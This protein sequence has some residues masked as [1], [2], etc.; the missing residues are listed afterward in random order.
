MSQEPDINEILGNALVIGIENISKRTLETIKK[1]WLKGKYGFTPIPE[2]ATRL[3]EISTNQTYITFKKIVG[4]YKYT[5]YI[6]IGILLYELNQKGNRER[7]EE[8]K[9][10][11]YNSRDGIHAKYIIHIASTGVLL[12]VLEYL[13]DLKYKISP[14]KEMLRSE[15]ED[16]LQ[17]WRKVS[18]PISNSDTKEKIIE[19][20]TTVIKLRE[21]LLVIY[22]CGHATSKA[23]LIIAQLTKEKFFSK[24]KYLPWS[25]NNTLSGIAHYVCMC[26]LIDEF[27]SSPLDA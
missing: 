21:K 27:S 16:I 7:V 25:K 23:Q 10:E 14:T 12:E 22:A 15:F 17:L 5:A 11:V 13:I 9:R 6:K 20:I 3:K 1:S 2:E 24:N 4:E 19:D 8:I 18:V 26:Y